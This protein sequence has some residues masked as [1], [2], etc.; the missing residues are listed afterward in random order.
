[1]SLRYSQSGWGITDIE[2]LEKLATCAKVLGAHEK[3]VVSCLRLLESLPTTAHAKR[4]DYEKALAEA[5]Y[6][7]PD[8]VVRESESVF[9]VELVGLVHHAEVP[10]GS[11]IALRIFS[12]LEEVGS[13][14]SQRAHSVNN[15]LELA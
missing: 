4:R 11:V 3:H 15:V 10:D 14:R 6:S 13:V 2:L 7:L 5:A 12:S 1:M 8:D 9:H